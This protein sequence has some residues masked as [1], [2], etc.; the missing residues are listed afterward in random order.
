[1]AS[2]LEMGFEREEIVGALTLS[3]ND[4]ELACEYLLSSDRCSEIAAQ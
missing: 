1:M 2:F 3:R 4:Y